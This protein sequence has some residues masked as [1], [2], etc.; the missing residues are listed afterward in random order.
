MWPQRLS[1]DTTAL[2]RF[3]AQESGWCNYQTVIQSKS[4][5]PRRGGGGG[6]VAARVR[7]DQG[8]RSTS[9]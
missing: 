3:E 4:E 1:S 8:S 5:G 2:C 7:P 6:R 9:V